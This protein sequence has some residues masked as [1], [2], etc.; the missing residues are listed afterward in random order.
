F[1]SMWVVCATAGAALGFILLVV[2][3][4]TFPEPILDLRIFKERTFVVALILTIAFSF[5]LFGTILLNPLFL[6]ELLGYSAW[7]TGL[8]QAPLGLCSGFSMMMTG[9]IARAGINTR[10]LVGLG[11][12]LIAVGAW[13]MGGMNPQ[14]SMMAVLKRNVVMSFG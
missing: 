4:L 3:E 11:F 13:R 6:Q 9:Q 5:V 14:V 8:V 1:E 2:R 7:K 12:T 10:P